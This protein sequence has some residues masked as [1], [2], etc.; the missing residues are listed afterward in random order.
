MFTCLC[1]KTLTESPE[2][3]P[4]PATLF[5]YLWMRYDQPQQPVVFASDLGFPNE[6]ASSSLMLDVYAEMQSHKKATS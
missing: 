3:H 5:L 1:P 6:V 2:V 4:L